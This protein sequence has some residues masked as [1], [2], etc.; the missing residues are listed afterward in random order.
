MI[1]Y[2]EYRSR[3]DVP[4]E[5][6]DLLGSFVDEQG[7]HVDIGVIVLDPRRDL[8]EQDGL[9]GLRRCDDQAPG[10]VADRAEEIDQTTGRGA[11][12]MLQRQAGLR[13][14]RSEFVE[15]LPSGIDVGGETL[16]LENLLHDR[17]RGAT[18]GSTTATRLSLHHLDGEFLGRPQVELLDQIGGD[19]RILG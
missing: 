19:E 13:I 2:S 11:P 1:N 10:S 4:P 16:D 3:G 18:A 7:D 12:A 8:L 6:R 15:G 5:V 17:A 14:D 9:S